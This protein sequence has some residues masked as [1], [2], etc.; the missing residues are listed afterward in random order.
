MGPGAHMVSQEWELM[1]KKPQCLLAYPCPSAD[2]V[3]SQFA[4]P[5]FLAHDC[6]P[7]FHY[8]MWLWLELF[9]AMSLLLCIVPLGWPP[10]DLEV[11]P[12]PFCCG[13]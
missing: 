11:S 12:L 1:K 9:G 13:Y 8:A 7:F 4:H 5:L 6:R 3:G 10:A 2:S